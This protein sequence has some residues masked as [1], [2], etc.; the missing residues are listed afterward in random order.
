M[1]SENLYN[2]TQRNIEKGAAALGGEN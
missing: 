1:E 2:M